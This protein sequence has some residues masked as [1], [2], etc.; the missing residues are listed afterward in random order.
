MYAT[1]D[2]QR[3]G[4]LVA[5]ITGGRPKLSERPT[6]KFFQQLHDAGVHD[7]VWVVSEKDAPHYERDDNELAVYPM[8]WAEKYASEHWM[9]PKPYES[10]SFFGAFV[11]RE[12]ACLEA[13]RRGCWGVMQLDDNIISTTAVAQDSAGEAT[14]RVHGGMG[15]IVDVLAGVALSTNGKMVGAQLTSVI[16]NQAKV[17]RPGFPYSCFIERVGDGREHW[18]GPFEDDIT[19]AFQYGTRADSSTSLVVPMLRYRKESKSKSGMRSKYNHERAVQLQRIFPES[20]KVV[21]KSTK[22]NGVRGDGMARVFHQMQAGAIRN[23]QV[24]L[25][26][27]LYGK[28]RDRVT[29]IVRERGELAVQVNRKKMRKRAAEG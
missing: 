14:L 5:V 24:I 22:S 8:E 11:G 13:E 21:A 19:H 29:M 7:I 17:S 2:K 18:Y 27:E 3:G 28:V 15:F 10:G 6:R 1:S 4:L 23:P 20:A 26:R 9:N 12:W 25:D 16:T